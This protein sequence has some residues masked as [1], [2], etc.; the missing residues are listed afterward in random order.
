MAED[1]TNPFAAILG[2]LKSRGAGQS[3]S[4]VR[5]DK[6]PGAVS[7]TLTSQEISR[8]TKIFGVMKG[9]MDPG[10]EA[11]RV[12]TT[13]A[14][15]VGGVAQMQQAESKAEGGGGIPFGKI[16]GGLALAAGV[17]GAAL[18]TLTDDIKEKFQAMA[19][20]IL[21][22]GS[23]V[24]VDLGHLPAMA[25]KIAKFIPIKT[26][27]FLPLIGSLIS[28]GMAWHHF[29]KNEYISALW[30]L[31]SGIANLFPGIGTAISVGM[32]MIKFFYEANA[33]IDADTGEAMDFG[34]FIKMKAKEIGGVVLDKIKEGKVPL[35]SGAWKLGEAIGHFISKDWKGGFKALREFLPALLGQ[36]D[37]KQMYQAIDALGSMI[38]DSAVGQKAAEMAADSWGWI[39]D[40]F[41]EIGE[42]FSN[43]FTAVKDWLANAVKEGLA[44][45][46]IGSE[47]EVPTLTVAEKKAI[48]ER[49]VKRNSRDASMKA[50][51]E[52]DIP[53]F[54]E[55]RK[56]GV[57]GFQEWLRSQG[58]Q[59]GTIHDGMISKNGNVTRFDDRDDVLAAKSGG[60]I[61]KLLDANSAVMSELNSVSKNQLNVLI[62]IR[63]GINMLVSKSGGSNN[64]E[65]Q[66]TTNPLTQE[67]YA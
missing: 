54:N 3:T 58:V 61:D 35:L 52:S 42:V 59:T 39:K 13:K 43:M 67:F 11:K 21:D 60:P 49:D 8:Y 6:R 33:P 65:V 14:G 23:E 29:Q 57:L 63:D 50:L 16:I 24:A 9:V 25:L 26:L 62:S 56:L 19:T 37:G 55:A 10:P 28:F 44:M 1:S 41:S 2:S 17:I 64:T 5:K 66:F 38:G 34:A 51:R 7:P 40:V 53:A 12:K 36:G 27:K 20:G 18:A 4:G 31:T 47:E 48:A 22:F 15:K 45:I 30:E 32:D 46:G